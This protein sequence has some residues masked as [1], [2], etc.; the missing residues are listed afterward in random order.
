MRPVWVEVDLEAVAHNFHVVQKLTGAGTK[1]MAVVKANA[2]GHGAV[3]VARRLR[4]A[5]ASYFGVATQQ[6][7]L[8]LREA[9]VEVPILILGFTP[10]EDAEATVARGITQTVFSLAQ[11]EALSR[12]AVKLGRPA[13]VHV[14]LDTGMGRLGVPPG[15]EAARL[16]EELAKLPGLVVEG[17]FSHLARADEE[18][19]GPALAQIRR[20]REFLE[21]LQRKGFVVPLRHLANSAA[22]MEL[23]ESHLNLVRPGIMLYGLYPSP[24]RRPEGISL[25]PALSWKARIV[26]LKTVP[27]G[28]AISYGG[29][30]VTERETLVATLP[31]GYA[32]G[33]RRA[34]S[35]RGEVIVRGRKV[36][37]IG[38]VCMDQTMV[39]VTGIP[40]VA[41]GD[42]VTVIGREGDAEISAADMA[43]LLDT[44][45]YEVVVGIGPR[46]GRKYLPEN[47]K[48]AGG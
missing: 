11:G 37:I 46:V 7:A 40:G 5:G 34:L 47:T 26:Q 39:D 28:T 6:E 13:A 22:V 27:P 41:V 18:D 33:L 31:L 32:D 20:F 14:K 23:P 21:T 25:R 19:K 15:E 35:N 2:Y 8:E 17:V 42:V 3:E 38:R 4:Q 44:I 30:Y 48:A 16:I 29:S 9:G 43:G 1:V 24:E 36:P 45:S 10:L 12:A